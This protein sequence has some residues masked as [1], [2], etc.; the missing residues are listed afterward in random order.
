MRYKQY[1]F[2]YPI[3]KRKIIMALFDLPPEQLQTY[4]PDRQEPNDFD[5]F[6]NQTLTQARQFPLDVR[7]EPVEFGLKTI[8]SFDLTFNGF[9]GQPIKG[10]LLLP[11]TT[12]AP[13]S[14]PAV[15]EYIGYG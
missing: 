7:L 14:L 9:G 3:E 4:L 15:V 11:A 6:W 2:L 1:R 10:W 12:S 8:K 13:Q 5:T